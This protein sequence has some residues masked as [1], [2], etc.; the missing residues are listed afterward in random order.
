M[1]QSVVIVGAGIIGAMT[2]L[3]FAK[4][5][6][7]VRV[8]DAGQPSAT[9]ASFGWINASFFLDDDHHHFRAE[10][11]A[12]WRRLM[13]NAPLDISWRGC[14]CWDMSMQDQQQTFHKLRA[15]DYPV[16]QLTR[17]QIEKLVPPLQDPP[18]GALF[19]PNEGA[20]SSGLVAAQC[21]RLAQDFGA[22]VINNVRVTAI[23]M[24]GTRAIG[25][26]T[27]EGVLHADQV[28]VTAG[29]GSAAITQ[30]IGY[31][32][33][34]VKRPAYIMRTAPVAPFLGLVL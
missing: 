30:S 23:A 25:V 29:I 34:M 19:F 9:A 26:E 1:A 4:S 15:F 5:G 12:A 21:L 31:A 20:V 32:V 27:T 6:H 17:S 33:P 14:V 8:V 11:I 22:Q 28:T 2:A 18:A 3:Q 16:E 13:E 10:G 7:S 24:Q